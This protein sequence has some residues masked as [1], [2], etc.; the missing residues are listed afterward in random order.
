MI[1][2]LSSSEPVLLQPPSFG[3][4]V[5][6]VIG[7]S[8]LTALMIVARM[9]VFVPAALLHCAIRHGRRA[10]WAVLA[11]TIAIVGLYAASAPLETP[12]L[13]RMMWASLGAVV[14]AIAFPA[15]AAVPLVARAESFGRVLVFLIAGSLVGLAA[16]EVAS[17]MLFAFSPFA[18]EVAQTKAVWLEVA[19]MYRELKAPA[20][21][22]RLAEQAGPVNAYVLP[23]QL[24]ASIA[25]IY[26]LSLL[27]YGR[28]R[29]WQDREAARPYLFRNLQLPEWLLF[30]FIFGG[31]TPIAGGMLQKV[32]ANT[33]VVVVLLYIVQGLAVVRSLMVTMGAGPVGSLFTWMLLGFLF[34]TGVS[35]V[36][37]GVLGLFD[38]FFDFRH[39]KKRKDDSHESH[40]D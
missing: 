1:E 18:M 5:R 4:R 9:P 17:R 11:I 12:D 6:S 35:Q 21:M 10:A 39:F 23:G 14:V 15:M 37:L 7:Y 29:G 40:S 28:L 30:A 27:M 25:V 38:P 8:L 22:I 31:L 26:V 33:L 32:A 34:F 19:K 24:I 3:R 2:P 13:Q 16:T 36:L 20:E